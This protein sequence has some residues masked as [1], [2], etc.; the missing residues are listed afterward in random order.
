MW[1][2]ATGYWYIWQSQSSTFFNQQHGAA[3][4]IPVPAAYIKQTIPAGNPPTNP[5]GSGAATPGSA[6]AGGTTLLTVTVTPGANPTSTGIAVTA[7]LT[8]VGGSSTQTFYDNG[9]N[10]DAQ[11][12]DNVFSFNITVAPGTS[13][14]SK[15]LPA[16]ITDA[17]SRAANAS[18]ALT[19]TAASP[20]GVTPATLGRARL[21]PKNATGGTNLYS[22]NFG[23]G[24]NLVNLPGRAGMDARLSLSY[25]SLVWTRVGNT[26]VFDADASNF[27]LGFR[28]GFPV[29]EPSYTDVQTGQST[30]LMVSPSGARTELRQTAAGVYES[31][32]SSYLQLQVVAG[33]GGQQMVLRSTDGTQM[34]FEWN[35]NAY[36]CSE[37]KDRNGNFITIFHDANGLLRKITDTLGRDINVIYDPQNNPSSIRQNWKTGNG[38]GSATEHIYASFYYKYIQINPSF[39]SS[40]TVS[41]P[42]SGSSIRVLNYISYSS[43]SYTY[44]DYN[45]FGQVSKV[46]NYAADNHVLNYT[47]TNLETP[48]TTADCP[49]LTETKTYVENFN[50]LN[51]IPAETITQ[52]TFTEDQSCPVAGLNVPA[53]KVTVSVVG[54]PHDVISTLWYHPAGSWREGLEF[55]SQDFG[56]NIERRWTATSWTQDNSSLTYIQNPRVGESKVGDASSIKRAVITYRPSSQGTAIAEF[57][58]VSKVQTYDGNAGTLLKEMTT[59]YNLSSAY[60]SRRII[61][62][63]SQVETHGLNQETNQFEP[64]SKM[65]YAYD[66]GNLS[67]AGQNISPVQHDGTNYSSGFVAGRGNLT[68]TTRYDVSGQ[69]AATTSSVKYNTAGSPVSQIDPLGREMTIGYT[70]SFND[71]NNSRNTHAYPTKVTEAAN[72]D[73]NNN[74]STIQYRYDIGANVQAKSPAPHGNTLGKVTTRNFDSV[75]RLER[76]SI[77][78]NNLEYSYTRYDYT[79]PDRDTHSRV[80]STVTDTNDNDRGD[81]AEEVLSESWTDGAGRVIKSR[82]PMTF[83]GSGN[84]ITWAGQKIEYDILGQVTQ[85]SVPTEVDANWNLAGDDAV[86]GTW[87]WTRQKYD[88]KGRVTRKINTD[89]AD[90]ADTNPNALTSLSIT[91]AAAARADR[92]RPFKASLSS[93]MIYR[94]LSPEEHRKSTKTFWAEPGKR[95]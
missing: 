83:D 61:G 80:F 37:I 86:R 59:D 25:N 28:F 33:T 2:P 69:T 81:T 6:A 20:P 93:A 5:T 10:G 64:V 7:N 51:G 50:G 4:D 54:A 47:T 58:L 57:G 44:F 95:R 46:T 35:V 23:W 42:A 41:G 68:S 3:G 40:L 15:S 89:G 90:T 9:T 67:G 27:T 55:A 19:V 49:K 17:Q 11:A 91:K 31:A 48:G 85:Q 45:N 34:K 62:L 38:D 22:R 82:S 53:T 12:G 94:I 77:W 1:R 84:A 92:K 72:T 70:D 76:E 78:K 39:D 30:H 43:G 71:G 63:P 26:M 65:T 14:G 32:D 21:S 73:T 88:W 60:T 52:N 74:Y 16:S 18:I 29:I 24:T 56:D 36:R 87:L 75:G 13:A 79:N 8:S 66:E